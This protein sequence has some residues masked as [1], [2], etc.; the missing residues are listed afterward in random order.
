QKT[1]ELAQLK[2]Q[3]N[4]HFLFNTLNTIYALVDVSPEDAKR[5]VHHLSGLLRYMLYEDVAE[6][7]LSQET[8]FIENYVS[9]MRMRLAGRDVKVE[10]SLDGHGDAPVPPLLF[11][12]LI[13][14]AFKYGTE[15]SS[16]VP[17]EIRIAVERE[18]VICTTANSFTEHEST[19]KDSGIGLANLRRRLH[20][21][22]GSSAGFST[23][24]KNNIFHTHLSIPLQDS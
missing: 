14:N 24:V 8:D 22:Y 19:R 4:P 5:A 17:V 13:E 1:M 12:P 6:V 15:D 9:L 18:R 11:I 10:I 21:L 16:E 7:K 23:E 20:L 2:S 3:L